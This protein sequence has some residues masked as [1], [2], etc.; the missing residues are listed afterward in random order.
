MNELYVHSTLV[1]RLG[2]L[3]PFVW[4]DRLQGKVYRQVAQR[5][6]LRVKID[7]QILFLKRHHGVG[8]IEIC[9]NLL[10]GRLP[11]LG[12]GN[13]FR[14]ARTLGAAGLSVP[15]PVAYAERGDN[16]ASR[17]S[18]LLSRAIEPSMSLEDLAKT[19]RDERPLVA[20]RWRLLLAVA[21][22]VALMHQCGVNHR[23]LYICHFLLRPE[24]LSAVPDLTLIDLHRAQIRLSVPPR[25]LVK[26]LGALW[27]S[28][29]DTL[30]TRRD[31]YRFICRYSKRSLREEL[32]DANRAKFWQSVRDR[33][34]QLHIEAERKG[35]VR[36]PDPF[37]EPVSTSVS[38]SVGESSI[39]Q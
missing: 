13:E 37:D 2:D 24:T 9:K 26:D 30:P 7:G 11:V 17:E 31:A 29:A 16:P 38:K 18:F 14:A 34:K 39:G 25:W 22:M 23:D 27:F 20:D 35:L 8:W 1:K 5:R 10:A 3:D 19:W 28:A 15:E 21:D 12:A 36:F 6:T 33:A 4:V 32:G